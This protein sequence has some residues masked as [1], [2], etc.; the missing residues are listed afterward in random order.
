MALDELATP[1]V[2]DL[3]DAFFA[4]LSERI[5]TERLSAHRVLDDAWD[6]L[7][8]LGLHH[9]GIAEEAGGGGGTVADQVA[10]VVGAARHGLGSR[11]A[12]TVIAQ[13]LLEAVGRS[14]A[15]G[16]PRW[17]LF[18]DDA[19]EPVVSLDDAGRVT[20][21]LSAVPGA[22]DAAH[23]VVLSFAG[24]EAFVV[25]AVLE[26]RPEPAGRDLAGTPLATVDLADL[27]AQ[28]TPI[29]VERSAAII[30][31]VRVAQ[32]S[33][34]VSRL[35]ALSIEH[36]AA[37]Q[38][39]GRPLRALQAVQHHVV[40]VAQAATL[41]DLAVGQATPTEDRGWNAAACAMAQICAHQLARDALASA[42]QVHG[43]IGLTEEYPLARI[44]RDLRSVTD[45]YAHEAQ[46]AENLGATV[47][48]RGSV[49]D[50]I[51]GATE[52]TV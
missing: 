12:D 39:F 43:A 47:A 34:L 11:L 13:L 20:G 41:I 5:L 45:V 48:R 31:L 51:G 30:A 22:H 18:V 15:V 27:E 33:G 24:R 16:R 46:V 52:E 19:R 26:A 23:L 3:A 2:G 10:I 36:T 44:A 25:Q 50:V 4:P 21:V 1:G 9:A 6:E 29:P 40:T 32:V 42:H 7:T 14:I 38:Q 35:A 8:G 49:Y 37:R 17:C 28:V